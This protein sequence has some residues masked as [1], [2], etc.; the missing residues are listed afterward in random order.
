MF[1]GLLFTWFMQWE[2]QE[3]QTSGECRDLATWADLSLYFYFYLFIYLY[4]CSGYIPFYAN[5]LLLHCCG[6]VEHSSENS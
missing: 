1:I 3:E 6:E 2:V 4:L 5:G